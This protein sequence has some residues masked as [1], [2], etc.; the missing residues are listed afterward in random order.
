[1]LDTTKSIYMRTSSELAK[2]TGIF[3]HSPQI[4]ES[5]QAEAEKFRKAKLF[6]TYTDK[7]GK[8]VETFVVPSLEGILKE[9]KFYTKVDTIIEKGKASLVYVFDCT[10]I[11]KNEHFEDDLCFSF[12]VMWNFY[13]GKYTAQ[14]RLHTF[15]L[16]CSLEA[17]L[18][19]NGTGKPFC[20]QNTAKSTSVD[21]SGRVY[22]NVSFYVKNKKDTPFYR[23]ERKYDKDKTMYDERYFAILNEIKTNIE[24]AIQAKNFEGLGDTEV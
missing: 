24:T 7:D 9:I 16:L 2:Q 23:S 19:E 21:V 14:Q 1:M 17:Y 3:M 11:V 13:N 15:Y 12:S 18:Q 20:L 4:H 5:L 10:L 8:Q 22:P 6:R